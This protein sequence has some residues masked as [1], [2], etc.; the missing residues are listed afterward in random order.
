M[1]YGNVGLCHQCHIAVKRQIWPL[2]TLEN[3]L[4]AEKGSV[5]AIVESVGETPSEIL[6]LE[7]LPFFK[8][9]EYKTREGTKRST[10]I[11]KGWKFTLEEQI[12][13]IHLV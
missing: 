3:V 1:L 12:D 2:D 7:L 9:G 6:A 5:V 11:I 13:T 10:Q 8:K 4:S